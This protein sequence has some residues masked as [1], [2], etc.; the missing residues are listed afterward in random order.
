MNEFFQH[1]INHK[2]QIAAMR[3]IWGFFLILS[4]TIQNAFPINN[5]KGN[6]TVT[7]SSASMNFTDLKDTLYTDHPFY[8]DVNLTAQMG[9]LHSRDGSV[10]PFGIS[11]GTDKLEDG[12]N[13]KEGL[14]DIQ[15]KMPKWYSRQFD[16]TLMLNW[17]GF[18]YGTGF[19]ALK[20]SGYYRFLGK[21]RS[22]HGCVRISRDMAKFLYDTV[23]LGT[24]VLVHKGACLVTVAFTD[25]IHKYIHYSV[26]GLQNEVNRRYKEMYAGKYFISS[27]KYLLMDL[28][29]IGHQ[30][31]PLGI[32]K[33]ILRRQIIKSPALFVKSVIP[34]IKGTVLIRK[35]LVKND[36][37]MYFVSK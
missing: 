4:L 24:P 36:F 22:S 29:N 27:R 37:R 6:N 18:H 33:N 25:S 2:E 23:S 16:S 19:H 11:S 12:I 21:K 28:D 8:I 15:C 26:E 5:T 1:T 3:I 7:D 17:M 34:P 35:S 30:G 14:F 13:T 32:S 10:K 31:L 20:G 9:Y